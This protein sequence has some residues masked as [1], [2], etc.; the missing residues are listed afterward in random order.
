[1]SESHD[2]PLGYSEQEAR[3]LADQGVLLEPHTAD[4]LRRAGLGDGMRV[5]DIGCGVGDVTLLAARIVGSGGAVLGLDRASSSLEVARRRIA[6]LGIAQARFVEADLATFEPGETFDALIGRLVLLYLPDPVATLRR[7]SQ[8]L[9]PG[10]IVAFQEYDMT[11]VSQIP[12]SELFTQVRQW[13]IDTFVAAGAEL[14]MG[15]KLYSTFVHAGLPP[16][17]M[18]ASTLIAC[19]PDSPGYEYMSR[20]LRSLLPLIERSGIAN[21][22]EI[23]IDTLAAR[24]RA[25]AVAHE[26]VSFL[27]RMVS[28][29]TTVAAHA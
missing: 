24:L 8:H 12:A 19:G 13:I 4:L 22:E 9:R 26:R 21:I 28:A 23:D 27:P 29:W 25:D 7:L 2:Y 15:T 18:I 6:S 16:P 17:G 14:D 3:R 10:G 5:L 20:V 1:M 11:Q